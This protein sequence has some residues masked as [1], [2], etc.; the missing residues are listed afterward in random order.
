MADRAPVLGAPP[1]ATP[2]DSERT[3]DLADFGYDYVQALCSA[4]EQLTAREVKRDPTRFVHHGAD[5]RY[6]AE[7]DLYF[8]LINDPVAQD[9][10]G[11]QRS[12]LQSDPLDAGRSV[13]LR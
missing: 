13:K 4:I 1:I 9:R 8:S 10:F 6:A 7:R 12:M 11:R 3:P 2:L 5:L